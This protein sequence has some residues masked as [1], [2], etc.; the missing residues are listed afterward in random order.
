M[1]L[2]IH[3]PHLDM[4]GRLPTNRSKVR[5]FHNLLQSLYETLKRTQPIFI[6]RTPPQSRERDDCIIQYQSDR[7]GIVASQDLELEVRCEWTDP[8]SSA[9]SIRVMGTYLDETNDRCFGILVEDSSPSSN[10]VRFNVGKTEHQRCI[11]RSLVVDVRRANMVSCVKST[12][13]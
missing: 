12:Y 1:I 4:S 7:A 8:S 3:S 11:H 2:S 9:W 13:L 10:D 5:L 6:L